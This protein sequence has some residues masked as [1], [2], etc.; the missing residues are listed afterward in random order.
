MVKGL[1][2]IRKLPD[3]RT[4]RVHNV[5]RC[6]AAAAIVLSPS[7]CAAAARSMASD[8]LTSALHCL[9]PHCQCLAQTGWGCYCF[10]SFTTP[11]SNRDKGNLPHIEDIQTV[12]TAAN[13]PTSGL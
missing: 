11:H 6:A 3:I 10:A 9:R 5:P 7:Q 13:Q 12:N 4:P 1:E 8:P 2:H